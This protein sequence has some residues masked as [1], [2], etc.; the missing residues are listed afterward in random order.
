MKQFLSSIASNIG[1]LLK[2]IKLVHVLI[3]IEFVCGSFILFIM[4]VEYNI[5]QSINNAQSSVDTF[6]YTVKY[7]GYEQAL[8][9]EGHYGSRAGAHVVLFY[10]ALVFILSIAYHNLRSWT[11]ERSKGRLGPVAILKFAAS[12]LTIVLITLFC[13]N[14]IQSAVDNNA[15]LGNCYQDFWYQVLSPIMLGLMAFGLSALII[16]THKK[17]NG[18]NAS[19]CSG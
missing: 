4:G 1:Q 5:F 10:C 13:F 14:S 16:Y 3:A 2:K 17:M 7:Y 11:K 6:Y 9:G 8:G 15:K 18:D 19:A 12:L